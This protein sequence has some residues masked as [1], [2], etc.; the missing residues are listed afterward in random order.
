MYDW[1]R[2]GRVSGELYEGR[3]R[4][5]GTPMQLAELDRELKFA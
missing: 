2:K 5:V 3:W 4:N 1:I